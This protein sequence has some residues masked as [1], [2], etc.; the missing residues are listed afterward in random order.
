MRE[1]KAA[2]ADRSAHCDRIADA[3]NTLITLNPGAWLRVEANVHFN[4]KLPPAGTINL[5]PG[6]W[7]HRVT[8]YPH[9]GGSSTAI[10]NVCINRERSTPTVRVHRD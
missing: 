8:F 2:F 3:P 4:L 9:P 7:I 10:E 6:Y 5:E 1:A